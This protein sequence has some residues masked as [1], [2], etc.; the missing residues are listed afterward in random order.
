MKRLLDFLRA[1]AFCAACFTLALLALL[2]GFEKSGWLR[3]RI[4]AELSDRLGEPVRVDSAHLHWFRPAVEIRGLSVGLEDRLWI[5]SLAGTLGRAAG[6]VGL[7]R[8]DVGGG[9]ILL[10]DEL[11]SLLRR[12]AVMATPEG[13]RSGDL[14]LPTI[15]VRDLQV[16]L[17]HQEWGEL[18]IGLVD[19]L[20]IADGTGDARIEGRIVPSLAQ[21]EG[22]AEIYLSGRQIEEGLIE[23]A[24]STQ[25]VFVTVDTLP[26]GTALEVF[27]PY[28]PRGK[29]ALTARAHLSIDGSRPPSGVLRA[30]LTEASVLP[31]TTEAPVEDLRIDLTANYTPQLDQKLTAS[32]AWRTSAR[33]RASWNG[34]PLE[35]WAFFGRNAGPGLAVSGW[36][37]VQDLRVDDGTPAAFGLEDALRKSWNALEPRGV[38][39]DLMVAAR[40]PSDGTPEVAIEVVADGRAGVSYH[41]WPNADGVPQGV[42]LPAEQVSGRLLI[43]YS[44]HQP[45]YRRI[46][47]LHAVGRHS[48]L[49][50]DQT[51]FSEG[52]VVNPPEGGRYPRIDLRY[53]AG[54]VPIDDAL[55]VALQGLNGTDSIWPLFAPSGGSASFEA[56]MVNSEETG[57]RLASHFVFELEDLEASYRDLPVPLSDVDGRLELLFG[58]G[59]FPGIGFAL[60]GRTPT[61][62]AI[63]VRGRL[64]DDPATGFRDRP[65][66][67][68]VELLASN[69]ALRGVDRNVVVEHM[70][71]VGR[72]L[73]EMGA[74]GKVDDAYRSGAPSGGAAL[75]HHVE[76]TPRQVQVFPQ[77]F[78]VQTRNAVGRV[79]VS[80]VGPGALQLGPGEEDDEPPPV[81]V[82]ASVQPLV[83]DW[84]GGTVVAVVADFDSH[85]EGHV[86]L[87]G[88]GL[89]PSNRGLVGAL[90][91]AFSAVGPASGSGMDLSVL[92]IEGRVDFT[93]DIVLPLSGEPVDRYRLHLRD[94]D[95]RT[96]ADQ[97]FALG[98]LNGVLE[99]RDRVLHGEGITAVLG[100]TL[101]LLETARFSVDE[102]GSYR[103]VLEPQA[104]DLPLDREH[105]GHF[106]DEP[107]VEALFGELDWRG[108]IDVDDAVLLLTGHPGEPGRLE[109]RGR[110]TPA[111]MFVNLG[112]PMEIHDA[113]VRVENLVLEDGTVRAWM[114][115][116]DLNGRIADRDLTGA[117]MVL[118]YVEPRLSVL[119]LDG[120]LEKGR[121]HNLAGAAA[122]AFSIDLADPFRFDLAVRMSGVDVAELLRGVFES[123][124]ASRGVLDAELRLSGNLSRITGI[125]GDGRIVLSEST[126][127]SIPVMRDLFSELGFDQT[128][129]FDQMRARFEVDGGIIAMNEMQVDSPLLRLV[130]DGSLDLD[131][132]L[133]HDLRVHYSL[134]DR[135][136]PFRRMIYF[137]QNNLLRVSVRGDMSRPRV[138]LQGALAFLQG[139]RKSKGRD[140]PLPGFAPL[141]ERF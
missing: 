115:V 64:M 6:G 44:E 132:R 110:V 124:F 13:D 133:H 58:P 125:R 96:G 21:G 41:G 66:I 113:G 100:S 45:T 130:G 7:S 22:P 89:D 136:G 87:F 104:R 54:D 26:E 109:F 30:A 15:V 137:V 24:A 90:G 140:L 36:A 98:H 40:L 17:S 82:H 122:P 97:R 121:V 94:N 32:E 23:I 77:R 34:A 141:P 139:L 79:L 51:V 114:T 78:K 131:G 118:T 49:A 55:R 8:I 20:C 135:L 35:G 42:P 126:L 19:A 127:W 53:G 27:R 70:P 107:A 57:G 117:R 129:V 12:V 65:E 69:L 119:A 116:D 9:R 80:A 59:L 10:S 14:T 128:A 102:D 84:H 47:W 111:D 50:E 134:V 46:G 81:R 73:D 38:V 71:G 75:E 85:A 120:E 43:H 83:G 29:L 11:A 39:A 99:E 63:R 88:A 28:A 1:G 5:E 33:V 72:A 2:L 56:H 61:S 3:E 74:A 103:A 16:D 92:A 68:D 106:L 31:P 62:D 67:S 86:Q 18:P 123:E 95:F 93:G 37:H 52:L 105:V 138:V 112:L 48:G 60:T 76:I 4:E 108:H 91:E 25:G 101:V